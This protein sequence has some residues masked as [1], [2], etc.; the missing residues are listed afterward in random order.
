MLEIVG[1]LV[2]VTSLGKWETICNNVESHTVKC[3]YALVAK[4]G[5]YCAGEFCEEEGYGWISK[6]LYDQY[7]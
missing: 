2:F 4:E 1:D 7:N 6:E 5:N 3:A